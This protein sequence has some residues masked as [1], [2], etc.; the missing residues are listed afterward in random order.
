MGGAPRYSRPVSWKG[1]YFP[2]APRYSSFKHRFDVNKRYQQQTRPHDRWVA[3][4]SG[5]IKI[6]KPNYKNM[7]PSVNYLQAKN[8][9]SKLI[10]KSLRKWNT[11]WVRLNPG[12]I[13]PAGT[14]KVA[15][16]PKFDKNEK[17]IWNNGR[18]KKPSTRND[19]TA[20]AEEPAVSEE[21]EENN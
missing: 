13:S 20:G 8:V 19:T 5:N 12:K 18:D 2:G 7:H 16:K 15:K 11:F 14:R 17:D 6:K 9:S 4:Y 1:A 21:S 10:R 3:E